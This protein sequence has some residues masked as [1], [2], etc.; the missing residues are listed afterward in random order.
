MWKRP[1]LPADAKAPVLVQVH[2]GAWVTGDKEGQAYPLMAHLAERGWVCVS[3]TY[4]LSPRP[5]GP[6]TSST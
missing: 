1:D 5:A 2:G 3:I 4:R 6:T